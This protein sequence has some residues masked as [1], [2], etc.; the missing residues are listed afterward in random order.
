MT[1]DDHTQ[2]KKQNFPRGS[3]IDMVGPIRTCAVFVAFLRFGKF[4]IA[5]GW[6]SS[7]TKEPKFKK[8]G[9]F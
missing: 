6:F 4:G 7:E 8:M 5:I 2:G 3:H 9:V 1:N